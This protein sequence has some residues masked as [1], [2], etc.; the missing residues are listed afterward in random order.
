MPISRR[1]GL[2]I[3]YEKTGT[4]PPLVLI[5]A[6]PFD[7]HMWLYQ[8]DRF[9]RHY[10]VLAMD[11]RALG[12]SAKPDKPC[13]LRDLASDIMGVLA[14]EHVSSNAVVMG[15]S[16][17][18]KLAM[19][20]ACDH[21]NV[22]S[23]CIAVGGTSEPQT[24][25]EPRIKAYLARQQDGTMGDYHMEH[26]RHGVTTSWADAPIGKHLI[27]RF[28]ERARGLDARA[29]VH[30]FGALSTSDLTGRLATCNVPILIIN[31]E[32]DSALKSGLRTKLLFPRIEQMILPG[33][34]HCCMLED[35]AGFDQLVIAFLARHGI[36]KDEQ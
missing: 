28:A 24:T 2:D 7:H 9:S 8:A 14:D 32:H 34:G 11:L 15:C 6:I 1:N 12:Q 21:P 33:T 25:F 3:Y 30:L 13:T 35:P 36:W 31:G 16:I 19:Q 23:A 17:G 27:S 20:L 10:T 22:F 29:L 5:H 18:S 26:L 4:G